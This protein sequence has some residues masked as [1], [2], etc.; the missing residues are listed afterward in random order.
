MKVGLFCSIT[1]SAMQNAEAEELYRLCQQWFQDSHLRTIASQIDPIR[2]RKDSFPVKL[3]F[4]DISSLKTGALEVRSSS[5]L[6]KYNA[7]EQN[8]AVH[9]LDFPGVPQKEPVVKITFDQMLSVYA[10]IEAKNKK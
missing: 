1:C 2:Q 6:A 8:I 4:A 5:A 10:F 9:K 3:G 7:T